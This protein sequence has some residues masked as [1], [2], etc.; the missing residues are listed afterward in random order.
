MGTVSGFLSI[1]GAGLTAIGALTGKEDVLKLGS[2][3]SLAG[4]LGTAFDKAAG[5]TA[6]KSVG[7]AA[8]NSA[9]SAAAGGA[10]SAASQ[11]LLGATDIGKLIEEAAKSPSGFGSTG[12]D[13]AVSGLD[14][15]SGLGSAAELGATAGAAGTP[16]LIEQAAGRISPAVGSEQ[17]L[18]S[19]WLDAAGQSGA[20][21]PSVFDP[22]QATVLDPVQAGAKQLDSTTLG[23]LLKKGVA[24]VDQLGQWVHKNKELAQI[25]GS[26]LESMYGPGAERMDLEKSILERRRRNMNSPVALRFGGG[27]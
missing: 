25:G 4:G 14:A 23:S 10:P 16:G 22:T 19:R 17:P 24:K 7:T 2:V 13:A 27:I 5:A 1:A 18:M 20:T 9:S 26:M 11:P 15:A 3:M 6:G 8:G 12:L 21:Q